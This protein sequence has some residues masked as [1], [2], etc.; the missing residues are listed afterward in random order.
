MNR[1]TGI[2]KDE[3]IKIGYADIHGNRIGFLTCKGDTFY[4]Y[5]ADSEGVC[6]KL[7]KGKSP[8]ELEEKYG[9]RKRMG[10]GG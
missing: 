3:E 8:S 7:G 4:L 1:Y 10:A 5:E 2:R 6:R 9:I